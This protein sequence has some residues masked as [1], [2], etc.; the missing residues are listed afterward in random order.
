MKILYVI[1]L[2]NCELYKTKTY[3]TFLKE[4][5]STIF[6]YDNSP[7]KQ[8]ISK[9]N[10]VYVHDSSNSGLS[11]AYNKA[12][13]Y[14]KENGFDWILLT[15]QD[16]SF[17][18]HALD[19]YISAINSQPDIKMIVPIHQIANGKFIS[20][21]PYHLKGSRPTDR[22]YFGVLKFSEA[23]PINSGM[24]IHVDAFW[25]VGGYDEDVVLDFSD[26]RFIEKFKKIFPVFYAMPDVVC[27]QD[28]S[29][30]EHDAGKLMI[31]FQIY[32]RCALACKRESLI[33]TFGY[34]FV[35]L[36]RTLRLT[37]QC[38]SLSFLQTYWKEYLLK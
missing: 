1:V 13:Q 33:D 27:L 31:R 10:V 14:A 22:K 23:A 35:T 16:T 20:P 26:V 34:F 28:F 19:R 37:L 3:S 21:T 25:R 4:L 30:N 18:E 24:L 9:D 8:N 6:I 12:A 36:K 5:R 17:P 32:L 7:V 11:V 2:Y 38:R 29:I 15:D